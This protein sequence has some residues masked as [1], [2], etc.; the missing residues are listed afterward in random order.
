MISFE[1]YLNEIRRKIETGS[2]GLRGVKDKAE[3]KQIIASKDYLGNLDITTVTNLSEL[4][5]NNTD[6]NIKEVETWDF[7][8]VEYMSRMFSGCTQ[9]K[10]VT[11][12]DTSSVGSMSQMFWNCTQLQEVTLGN[13]SKVEYMGS[14]FE[15]CSQLK[16]V[17]LNDTSSVKDMGRMFR[18][19]SQ[20]EK[21]TLGD[22]SNVEQMDWLFKGCA[23]LLQDFSNLKFNI[24]ET[25]KKGKK[26]DMFKGCTKMLAKP[27]FFPKGYL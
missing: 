23:Q 15:G 1:Q 16:E 2:G 13:T 26:Y 12:G 20:L 14:M 11:L 6:F 18:F 21:V 19:C 5:K 25:C 22:T 17:T 3:L 8:K 9:L 4:F 27:E 10:E 24:P 7:S